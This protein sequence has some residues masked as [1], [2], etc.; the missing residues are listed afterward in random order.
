MKTSWLVTKISPQFLTR[1]FHF[2][3]T[4]SI[5]L[6]PWLKWGPLEVIFILINGKKKR[7]RLY[8]LRS[9]FYVSDYLHKLII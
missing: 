2:T 1:A 4:I 7:E 6:F 5:L 3:I 8:T 9:R